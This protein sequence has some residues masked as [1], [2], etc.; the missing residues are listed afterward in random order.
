MRIDELSFPQDK[1]GALVILKKAGYK[2]AGGGEFA[3]VFKKD[4][5][6]YVL[7]IF[8][9]RDT[10]YLSYIDVVKNNQ[11]NKFIPCLVYHN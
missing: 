6:D 2:I 9:N 3:T 4:S 5:R 1:N 10:A 8:E 7:K 11:S